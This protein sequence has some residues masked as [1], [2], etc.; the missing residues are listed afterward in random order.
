M[1]LCLSQAC[2]SCLATL[3]AGPLVVTSCGGVS[4]SRRCLDGGYQPPHTP[5]DLAPPV[6]VISLVRRGGAWLGPQPSFFLLYFPLPCLAPSMGHPG[7]SLPTRTLSHPSPSRTVVGS[8]REHGSRKFWAVRSGSPSGPYSLRIGR[9]LLKGAS[10]A[11][12]ALWWMDVSPQNPPTKSGAGSRPP[13]P[14]EPA[15]CCS[16]FALR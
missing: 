9:A 13:P 12:P 8:H 7:V 1:L 16:T 14:C 5:Q 6:V 11:T 2:N 15:L 3:S 10:R 4:W